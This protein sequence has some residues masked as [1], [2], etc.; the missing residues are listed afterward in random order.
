M[1]SSQHSS[2]WMQ[3][4][5]GRARP[6]SIW[7]LTAVAI[8]SFGFNCCIKLMNYRLAKHLLDWH[9]AKE[10][11]N[12][13]R[14][15]CSSLIRDA[16]VRF[17]DSNQPPPH[18]TLPSFLSSGSSPRVC[19]ASSTLFPWTFLEKG[20]QP[21]ISRICREA[22]AKFHLG[23]LIGFKTSIRFYVLFFGLSI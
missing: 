21:S 15:E 9:F 22:N 2:T 18:S 23:V 14:C 3:G 5:R 11:I 6:Q 12:G 17:Y 7:S 20:Y 1:P 19:Y 13:S 4:Q 8:T 16:V 10:F